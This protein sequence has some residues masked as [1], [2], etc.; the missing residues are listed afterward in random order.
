V[1]PD[2]TSTQLKRPRVIER[3]GPRQKVKASKLTI[4]PITLMEANLYDIGE[5]VCDV[6]KEAI[7]ELMSE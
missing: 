1:D 5:T 6:A 4:D 3:S 2:T 7:D